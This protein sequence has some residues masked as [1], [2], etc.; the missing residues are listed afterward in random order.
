VA[1]TYSLLGGYHTTV[2]SLP[3]D[4]FRHVVRPRET[5]QRETISWRLD[6]LLL[7]PNMRRSAPEISVTFLQIFCRPRLRSWTWLYLQKANEKTFPMI[8]CPYGNNLNFS[9]MFWI[10]FSSKIGI[11]NYWA[12]GANNPKILEARGPPPNT[13]MR[14][15]NPLTT[16]NNSWIGSCTFAQLRNNVPIGYNGM[17][18]IHLPKLPLPIWW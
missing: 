10:H 8:Y 3:V 9:R 18:Q 17:P 13:S 7:W 5:F 11:W 4:L 16:P 2:K 14:G 15:S 12:I 6:A 1:K